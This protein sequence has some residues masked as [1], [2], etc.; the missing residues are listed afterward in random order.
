[1]VYFALC[2]VVGIS[3]PYYMGH[4]VALV[5]AGSLTLLAGALRL[6]TAKRM[7]RHPPDPSSWTVPVFKGTT[8]ATFVVWGL[9]CAWTLHWYAGEWTGMFLLLCTAVLAGGASHSL[10]PDLNLATRCLVILIGPTSCCDLSFGR[11][12]VF[13]AR[14]PG[15]PLPG[16]SLAGTVRTWRTFWE[17]SAAAER[18][19]MLGSAERRRAETERASLVA[20][21]E[22][23]AAEIVITDAEGN[24]QYC[25]PSFEQLTGYPRSEVIGR[26]PRFLKSGEH[27][28][29]FYRDL[30]NTILGGGIWAGRF[31]N[32]KKDGSLYQAEGTISPI[33]DVA[34]NLTRLRIGNPRRHRAASHGR[35]TAAGAEN[36]RHRPPG[37]R[38][39][40]RFQ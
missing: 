28:A 30:W 2:V 20:A 4:P 3:T 40:A 25:N 24:I 17:A 7:L 29:K 12:A 21:V 38:R 6:Y 33:H 16:S 19:I 10:A 1:M 18:E 27:D 8:Y 22:Q 5:V 26:N 34:G 35:S 14:R 23:I 32:R 9:F 39:G 15:G 36:G 13:R 31:T 11:R 37:G